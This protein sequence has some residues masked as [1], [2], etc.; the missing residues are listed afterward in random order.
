MA[1]LT[2]KEKILLSKGPESNSHCLNQVTHNC[3]YLWG[4]LH[5][6]PLWA[7]AFQGPYPHT[8]KKKKSL[9]LSLLPPFSLLFFFEIEFGYV[10]QARFYLLPFTCLCLP[11]A[12][13]T[14]IHLH[15]WAS[16]LFLTTLLQSHQPENKNR[17]SITRIV[18]VSFIKKCYLIAEAGA[19]RS[20]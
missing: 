11:G 15:R 10:D 12:R 18:C 2:I 16:L 13:I 8:L 4:Y 17:S 14:D 3:Q 6:W 5:L 9:A 19:N 7:A 20:L 1:R